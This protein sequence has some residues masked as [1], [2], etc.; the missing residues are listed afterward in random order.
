MKPATLRPPSIGDKDGCRTTV[1]SCGYYR[2]GML[3][4]GHKQFQ[5]NCP[6]CSVIKVKYEHN[7]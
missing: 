7:R 4:G 5:N 2:D 1:V 3:L 6:I